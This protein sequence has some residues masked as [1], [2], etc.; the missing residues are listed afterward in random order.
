MFLTDW[1]VFQGVQTLTI[2]WSDYGRSVIH[3][4]YWILFSALSMG[5]FY[6]AYN[7]LSG[8]YDLFARVSVHA[9]VIILVTKLVFLSVLFTEDIVRT[10]AAILQTFHKTAG[11]SAQAF[12]FP[13]RTKLVSQLALAVAGIPFISFI[14]GITKGKHN[15]KVHKHTLYFDDLPEGFDGFKIVQISDIHA[16]SLRNAKAIQRGIDLIKKQ[17]ADLFVFTGDLVNNKASEVEPWL[18]YF[19]QIKAPFGQFSV[20]GNHDYGDYIQWK[21]AEEKDYNLE[22]LK[23]HHETLGYRL[24][25]DKNVTIEKEGYR[26]ALLGVE[27]W[28]RGFA[29]KGDLQKTMKGIDDQTFKVLL[30]HD[31]SHWEVQV[32]DHP[33]T[34]H[35]TLSGHTHG[36]QFGIELGGMRWSPVKYRYPNWAGIAHHNGRYLNVNRGFG[37]LGFEGRVGIWPEIT[38]IELR[39]TFKSSL[40]TSG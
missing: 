4:G 29:M 22:Q 20:L 21:S 2:E 19:S 11:D 33:A 17:N 18:K 10:G 39:K 24:L 14:Y 9:F 32:K 12:I 37:F 1:Y 26:I 8:K 31:P 13:E 7:R 27:N 16:G 6:A 5:L 15:Y 36:M 30:S 25:L 28:G 34:I 3:S 35:L 23:K 38:V 40:A